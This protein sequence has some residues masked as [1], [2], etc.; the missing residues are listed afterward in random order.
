MLRASGYVLECH[1]SRGH[2]VYFGEIGASL[3]LLEAG[4]TIDS[5]LHRYQDVD[6][7]DEA[8]WQCNDALSPIGKR[9]FD[10]VTV[11]PFELVFPK[12]KGSLLESGVPSH[13]EVQRMSEWLS[14]PVRSSTSSFATAR[15][16]SSASAC[17]PVPTT[18]FALYLVGTID[19][20][21]DGWR[22]RRATAISQATG[23][24]PQTGFKCAPKRCSLPSRKALT[25]LTGHS[26]R[27]RTRTWRA[28]RSCSSGSTF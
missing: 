20:S 1:R 19:L 10:G 11:S 3:A 23:T 5:F 17:T 8:S 13:F 25:A 28:R 26:M 27:A 2:A 4:Y 12:L 22:C 15:G 16:Q 9:T 14:K 6:W 7:R 21:G 24:Q 18:T